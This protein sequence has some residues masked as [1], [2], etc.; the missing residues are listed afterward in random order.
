MN[1]KNKG[2]LIDELDEIHKK[3]SDKLFE[4][5]NAN[6]KGELVMEN[7]HLT[8]LRKE[9]EDFRDKIDI[10]NIEKQRLDMITYHNRK[11]DAFCKKFSEGEAKMDKFLPQLKEIKNQQP[12][13]DE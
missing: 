4:M 5:H 13:R 12:D 6:S 3:C 8:G 2:D 10:I 1:E 9:I 7:D 11:V